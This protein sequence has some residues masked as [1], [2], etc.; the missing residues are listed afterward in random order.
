[1]HDD[2]LAR[3]VWLAKVSC[4]HR[5]SG[6]ST[7]T[8]FPREP[9][10]RQPRGEDRRRAILEAASA[11][12]SEKGFAESSMAEIAARVGVVEGA[13][14]KHFPSKRELLYQAVREYLAPRFEA[15]KRALTAISGV[16]NRVRFL[17]F[18]HLREFVEAP[19]ICRLVIHDIRPYEDYQGSALRELIRDNSALLSSVLADAE[20][21]GEVKRGVQ[22][23]IVR[24]LIYGGIEHLA[25]RVLAGRATLDA[26][27]IADQ[28]TE[29]VLGGVLEDKRD[30]PGRRLASDLDRLARLVDGLER[31]AGRRR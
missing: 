14:Y 10:A 31:S 27:A 24:D 23:A 6:T 28:V 20:R 9:L 13:L 8:A 16:R 15:T 29:L 3:S 7:M 19:G 4:A 21:R 2:S 1:M 18:C 26:E 30:E 17:V 22:S 5:V 25:F 11:V 12:F